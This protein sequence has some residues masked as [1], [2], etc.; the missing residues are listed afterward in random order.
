[1]KGP[2][3]TPV[4]PTAPGASA[5]PAAGTRA[6]GGAR[7]SRAVPALFPAAELGSKVQPLS[8]PA[9]V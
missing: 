4:E 2:P 7:L 6:Q 9:S 3:E 8:R 1:M 5:E